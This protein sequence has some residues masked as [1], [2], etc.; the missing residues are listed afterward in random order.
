MHISFFKPNA[1]RLINFFNLCSFIAYIYLANYF[2]TLCTKFL[3]AVPQGIAAPTLMSQSPTSVLI[4]WDAPLAPNG[5]ILLYT[6]QRRLFNQ[7]NIVSLQ[8]FSPTASRQFVDTSPTLSPNTAYEYRVVAYTV[9]GAG[10]GP[11]ASVVTLSSSNHN[12]IIFYAFRNMF[13]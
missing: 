1:S 13:L 12:K 8:N 4:V 7:S 6:L 9:A 3:D 11:W 2:N 5:D 10:Y